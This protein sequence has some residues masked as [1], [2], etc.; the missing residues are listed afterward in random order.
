[1]STQRVDS[2][3]YCLYMYVCVCHHTCASVFLVV[4]VSASLPRSLAIFILLEFSLL[5]SLWLTVS[6]SQCQTVLPCVAC[7]GG[8]V[9][10]SNLVA[11]HALLLLLLRHGDSCNLHRAFSLFCVLSAGAISMMPHLGTKHLYSAGLQCCLHCAVCQC[12]GLLPSV[13]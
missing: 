5:V 8:H 1:M 9:I 6:G 4:S 12:R 3:V 7:R 10:V 11:A 2:I 13:R